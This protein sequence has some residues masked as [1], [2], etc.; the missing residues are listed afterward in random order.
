MA[1]D[2]TGEE[3]VQQHL[4]VRLSHNDN[5]HHYHRPMTMTKTHQDNDRED[6]DDDMRQDDI[7]SPLSHPGTENPEDPNE[8][9]SFGV[10]LAH[11][12]DLL[13]IS[14]CGS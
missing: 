1:Q 2:C 7:T 10:C 14:G 9:H 3:K 4:A 13:F 6:Q 11:V 5:N 12:V 8:F